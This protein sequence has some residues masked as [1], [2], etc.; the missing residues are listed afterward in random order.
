MIG[1]LTTLPD[2]VRVHLLNYAGGERKVNGLRVRV[3][4]R[5]PK[6]SR[7]EL[8]DYTV[9]SDGTEFTVPELGMYAVVDLAR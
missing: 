1:R 9:D 2:G 8:L 6:Y 3:A 4:G 5:Y 7:A